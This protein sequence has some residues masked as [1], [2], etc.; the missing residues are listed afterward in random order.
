M[1]YPT[2]R[3]DL[4]VERTITFYVA[5]DD[6]E[7]VERFLDENDEWQ[8]GDVPGLIDLVSDETEVD[9]RIYEEESISPGFAIIDGELVEIE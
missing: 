9:Q 5:A 6:A 4:V 2:F 8:P 3:V 7:S 1:T